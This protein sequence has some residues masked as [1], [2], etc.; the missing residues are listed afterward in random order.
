M[1]SFDYF[2]LLYLEWEKYFLSVILT[3]FVYYIVYKKYF[4][5]LLDPF[6]YA[7]FFSAMSITVPVFLYFT[8][9]VSDRLFLSLVITQLSF[10]IGFRTFG[11]INI[12][13]LKNIKRKNVSYQEIRFSKWL[14]ISIGVSNI[15]LQL[16]SYKF[17]GIPLLS[18]ARLNVYGESG[19]INN[20]LKRILEVTSQSHV[21]LT[22]FFL[23]QKNQ[24]LKIKVFARLSFVFIVFFSVLSGSKGAF[25]TFGLAF[26]IYALYSLRW[27]DSTIFSLIK[28]FIYK[29]G[30][31]AI[32]LAIIVISVG[33][34]SS[35]PLMFILLRIGQSGDVYYMAYPNEVIDKIPTMNWFIALFASPLSLLK[36]I[37]RDMVPEPMGFFLMKY[38]NPS[39]EFRGPN[40]RM[41]VFSYVYF[42]ILSSPIYCFIIGVITSFFRNKL[43]LL[44]PKN[45][46]GCILYFLLLNCALKLEPD[47]HFAL[48]D[49][50]NISLILPVF[51]IFSYYLSLRNEHGG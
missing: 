2:G 22:I 48:A 39:V 19:G 35:N 46:L 1:D 4:I 16:F 44:L 34:G 29:F 11:P 24:S 28:K 41:N 45:I 30:A 14:F 51:V 8:A 7:I 3:F 13:L 32:V 15:L 10:F 49:F 9:Q 26:F 12:N 43:F 33:E 37:P 5:S 23:Y 18:E 20:L 31:V 42:G 38:H 50:I 27:G 6:T 21:F 17:V 40:P 36:I 47:F 25:V